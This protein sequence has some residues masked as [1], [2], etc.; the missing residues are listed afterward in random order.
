MNSGRLVPIHPTLRA[1]LTAW[2]KT[3]TGPGPVVRSERGCAMAPGSIVNWFAIAYRAVG[4]RAPDERWQ[5][6]EVPLSQIAYDV[7]H[8]SDSRVSGGAVTGLR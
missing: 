7:F 6:F 2:R 8:R 3:T 1:A 5:L 4:L